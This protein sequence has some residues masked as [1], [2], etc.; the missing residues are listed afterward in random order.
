MIVYQAT[1]GEFLR[2]TFTEHIE[3]VIL[4]SWRRRLGHGLSRQQVCSWRE[5]LVAMAKV[6]N[7]DSIPQSCGIAAEYL[8]P[9]TARPIDYGC[10]PAVTGAA[11]RLPR[12][13][14][15]SSPSAALTLGY[16]SR[17][18][19]T[20]TTRTATAST[21]PVTGTGFMVSLM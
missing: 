16:W 12:K 5:S 2:T 11:L 13:L 14:A 3:A 10:P 18:L 7:H 19:P 9:Q 17:G 21:A 1:T 6:L 20:G 8:I 15:G 4:D